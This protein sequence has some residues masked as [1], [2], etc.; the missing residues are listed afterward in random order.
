MAQHQLQADY[1]K[2]KAEEA[3]KSNKLQE[4]MSVDNLNSKRSLPCSDN[5]FL[6]TRK[7]L[8]SPFVNKDMSTPW[9]GYLPYKKESFVPAEEQKLQKDMFNNLTKSTAKWQ[10]PLSIFHI[11]T[12]HFHLIISLTLLLVTHKCPSERFFVLFCL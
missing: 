9:D 6:N 8:P 4:L 5:K 11:H 3:E 10:Q 1:E 12:F 2:L 7:P